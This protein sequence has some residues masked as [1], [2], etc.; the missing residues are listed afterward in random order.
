[1]DHRPY[2]GSEDSGNNGFKVSYSTKSVPV[3]FSKPKRIS[4][5]LVRVLLFGI[6]LD[7]LIR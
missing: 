2:P 1:M 7:D 3:M 5:V 6:S 4:K